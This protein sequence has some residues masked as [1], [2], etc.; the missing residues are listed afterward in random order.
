M[1]V[2]DPM[3]HGVYYRCTKQT[4]SGNT[5]KILKSEARYGPQAAKRTTAC[6]HWS[7]QL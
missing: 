2:N 7:Q 4:Q 3:K 5:N 6:G 1:D